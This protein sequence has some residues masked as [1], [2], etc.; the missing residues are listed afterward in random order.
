LVDTYSVAGCD[1]FQEVGG[2]AITLSALCSC[3]DIDQDWAAKWN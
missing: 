1:P 3:I 2:V